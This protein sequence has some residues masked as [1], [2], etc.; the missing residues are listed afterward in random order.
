M[1]KWHVFTIILVIYCCV[2]N[3]PNLVAGSNSSSIM[4]SNS[5]GPEFR[6][7]TA[8]VAYFSSIMS[9]AS[10]VKVQMAVSGLNGCQ[11]LESGRGFFTPM[12][13]IW[14]GMTWRPKLITGA[15]I[16]GPSVWLGLPHI[17]ASQNSLTFH[18]VA[19]GSKKECSSKRGRSL[20]H[21]FWSSFRSHKVP[22]LVDS[23][24]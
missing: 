7:G 8:S 3:H 24:G 22:L 2:T 5:A 9:E 14:S 1:I 16:H 20:H 21:L 19:Q 13:G 6:Q 18:M 17:L 4:L 11:G 23:I 10:T 15:P 12:S